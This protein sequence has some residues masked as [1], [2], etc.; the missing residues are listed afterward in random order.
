MVDNITAITVQE[1]G[2]TEQEP[3]HKENKDK[4][5]QSNYWNMLHLLTI[6]GATS[7]TLSAQ[8]LIP[9][10]NSIH[11]PNYWF[12]VPLLISI[13]ASCGLTMRYIL[14]CVTFT[15]EKGLIRTSVVLKMFGCMFVP[16]AGIFTLS[17]IL[18]TLVNE[19]QPPMPFNGMLIFFATEFVHKCTLWLG[20]MFPSELRHNNGFREKL[21]TYLM[22]EIWWFFMHIQKD[23]LSF[24]F[25]IAGHFQF[26]FALLIPAV[27]AMNKRILRKMVTKMAGINDQDANVVMIFRLNIHYAL[28]VAV[29]MS[30]A[31]ILTIVS[32]VIVDFL[33]QLRMVH[34]IIQLKRKVSKDQSSRSITNTRMEKEISELLLAE[35]TEGLVPVVYV[36]GFSMAYYGPNGHLTGNVLSDLWSYE[37]VKDATRLFFV[38]FLLFGIDLVV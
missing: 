10:H 29:R 9:R 37:K 1:I 14:E 28:F 30:G 6:I 26:L 38:Q 27:K 11:Y 23:V 18:W 16:I 3:V 34:Q 2:G 7:L 21:K 4:P 31:E 32:V 8:L 12:E 20:I 36:I 33:L 35:L 17:H 25:A 24:G 15:K 22:Y 5:I 13:V 19:F